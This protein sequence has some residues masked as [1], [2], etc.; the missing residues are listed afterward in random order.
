L[1]RGEGILPSQR[2]QLLAICG[3]YAYYQGHFSGAFDLLERSVGLSRELG[4]P[5]DLA[6]A[7]YLLGVVTLGGG[8]YN[9]AEPLFAEALATFD[10]LDDR[11]WAAFARHNLGVVAFGRGDAGRAALRLA[12]ALAMHP[13]HGN[14]WA[15][16]MSL[17]YLG[18]VEC[19]RADLAA[20]AGRFRES[21]PLW[22]EVGNQG[23]LANWLAR[24]A[25]LSAKS[26]RVAP[27]VRLAGAAEALREA[28]GSIWELPERETYESTARALRADLGEEP[29]LAAWTAG[30]AL[31]AAEATAEA[32]AVL[33]AV[34]GA[35]AR[36]DPGRSIDDLTEREVDVLRLVAAGKTNPEIAEALFIGRGTVRT[37]VSSI[38]AKLG[39]RTRTEAADLARRRGLL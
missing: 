38:L 25:T 22:R 19:A 5:W 30:V 9:R 29:F 12:G 35:A 2:A 31:T 6:H 33:E 10:A 24:V 20:A 17:D 1:A 36:V 8:A 21:L 34:A 37:H 4:D 28:A 16:A 27:A 15:R 7:L 3:I 23:K 32:S 14:P 26:G 13:E 39:A 11:L 18:L